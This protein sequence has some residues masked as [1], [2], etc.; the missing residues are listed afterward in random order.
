LNAIRSPEAWKKLRESPVTGAP[1]RSAEETLAALVAASR[2][3]CEDEAHAALSQDQTLAPCCWL[4]ARVESLLDAL[5][6]VVSGGPC[7]LILEEG[8]IRIVT[9]EA[10]YRFWRDWA[11]Q[12]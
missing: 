7:D 1:G 9:R 4:E 5:E 11:D 2:L 12:K 8:R 10:A 6:E 3:T